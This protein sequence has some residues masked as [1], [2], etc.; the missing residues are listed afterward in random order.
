MPAIPR[1]NI[2]AY[3]VWGEALH[4][5]AGFLNANVTNATSF[6]NSVALGSSWDP[7]LWSV[8][9]LLFQMKEEAPIP[10]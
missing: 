6:P 4:G 9:P 2:R 7:A 1:L 3:Q 10:R 8:K 5:V